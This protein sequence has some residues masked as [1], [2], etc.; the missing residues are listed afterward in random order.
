MDTCKHCQTPRKRINQLCCAWNLAG[1]E[2]KTSKDLLLTAF[3][4]A[5]SRP[6]IYSKRQRDFLAKVAGITNLRK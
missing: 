5:E 4:T 1:T 2:H 3:D 6:E